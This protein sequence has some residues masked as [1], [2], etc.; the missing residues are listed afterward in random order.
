MNSPAPER[1]LSPPQIAE[2][3]GV[4]PRKVIAWIRSGELAA[5]NLAS[6][7]AS[8]PRYAVS[9]ASLAK[10]LSAKAVAPVAAPPPKADVRNRRRVKNYFSA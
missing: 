8:R 1:Y 2:R 6:R 5:V 9:P 10:F 4:A 7:G 3:L